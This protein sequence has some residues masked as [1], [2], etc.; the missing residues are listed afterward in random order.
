MRT[1]GCTFHLATGPPQVLQHLRFFSFL[2]ASP[3]QE[4]SVSEVPGRLPG[5]RHIPR[6]GSDPEQFLLRMRPVPD[7]LSNRGLPR[8]SPFRDLSSGPGPIASPPQSLTRCAATAL[9]PLPPGRGFTGGGSLCLLPRSPIRKRP[10][11]CCASRLRRHRADQRQ[12]LRVPA[13]AGRSAGGGVDQDL[14][15]PAPRSRSGRGLH[16]EGG[17]AASSG[18][19]PQGAFL[20]HFPPSEGSHRL[21]S[22]SERVDTAGEPDQGAAKGRPGQAFSQEGDSSSA[23]GAG[24]AGA[25]RSS[26]LRHRFSV[27]HSP[28]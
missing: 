12:V 11:R 24:G 15:N 9:H 23:C 21:G 10:G 28:D 5:R 6:P 3:V 26:G 2:P 1:R 18:P 22:I 4:E 8:R 25:R 27:G 20:L 14:E 17:E 13:A 7:G 19:R 16:S